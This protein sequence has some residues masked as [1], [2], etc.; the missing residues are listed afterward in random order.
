[1]LTMIDIPPYDVCVNPQPQERDKRDDGAELLKQRK[2]GGRGDHFWIPSEGIEC[3]SKAY[4][5]VKRRR[6]RYSVKQNIS[7][8]SQGKR[9]ARS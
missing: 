3:S 2:D 5:F 7:P 9:R 8:Q 1:M 6:L 4:D